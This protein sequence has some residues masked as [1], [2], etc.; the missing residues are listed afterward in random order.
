[1]AT[2]KT[3]TAARRP[4]RKKAA[5]APAAETNGKALPSAATQPRKRTRKPEPTASA[6][7]KGDALVVVES[8]TKAKSIGKYLGRGFDVKATIGHVRDL[9]TR[10]LGV[11]VEN[12]F[13]PEY[14]TIKGKTQTLN[15]LKRA[16]KTARAVYLAT[17]P[18]R[19]G[20]AIAWHVADQLD[21][22]APLHRVL[23]HEITKDAVQQAVA[24]PGVIDDDKVKAQQARRI[25]D[26]LVGYK[27][28][29]ILWHSIKT[30][31]SAGRVQT[32][33]LRL[34]VEREREIR[35]FKPQEYWTIEA[36]C[37]KNGQAF[38]AELKKIDGHNPH[39]TN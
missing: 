31:L 30:G 3:K 34:I 37:A 39:L 4:S 29:P 9:P 10:K 17:D 20:E 22:R 12:G 14:V 15:E 24:K 26:R 2:Q 38:D 27:A 25:L 36:A 35:A 19:E 13:Q 23:F 32:V 18:D 1:M 28:S 33:A 5:T 11:D 21:T 6:A 7:G 16:A 8:P